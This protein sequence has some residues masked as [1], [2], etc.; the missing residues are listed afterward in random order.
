MEVVGEPFP[1]AELGSG[2][3]ALDLCVAQPSV[4]PEPGRHSLRDLRAAS[5]RPGG[6]V[7]EAR[8]VRSVLRRR[9]PLWF[10]INHFGS[11]AQL[12]HLS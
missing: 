6:R 10:L 2:A 1:H 9:E 11:D 7:G 5:W 8:S 3:S 4:C 12:P